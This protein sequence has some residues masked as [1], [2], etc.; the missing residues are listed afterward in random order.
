[1]KK[2][3]KRR[4]LLPTTAAALVTTVVPKAKAAKSKAGRHP[5]FY[6][7]LGR[8]RYTVG[9]NEIAV[10]DER[11]VHWS[12]FA[13]A[14]LNMELRMLGPQSRDQ[15]IAKVKSVPAPIDPLVMDAACRVHAINRKVG[16]HMSIV[17]HRRDDYS[18]DQAISEQRW[19]DG[20][21]L[22]PVRRPKVGD[23]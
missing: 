12:K 19:I 7:Q 16:I 8:K 13:L 21:Y 18:S 4:A 3:M 10:D 1:M 22:P 15:D 2:P 5:E 17:A 11:Y 20:G 23:L 6:I 9:F 14:P